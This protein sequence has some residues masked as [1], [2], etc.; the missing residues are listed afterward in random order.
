MATESEVADTEGSTATAAISSWIAGGGDERQSEDEVDGGASEDIATEA[1][2]V[3]KGAARFLRT[4][5]RSELGSV[6]CEPCRPQDF[7]GGACA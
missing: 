4:A 1:S 6:V 3:I 5:P 7:G 2:E